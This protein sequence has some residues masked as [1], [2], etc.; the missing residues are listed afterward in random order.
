MSFNANTPTTLAAENHDKGRIEAAIAY[1]RQGWSA[2]AFSLLSGQ[3][4]EKEP[5]AQFA[6]GLCHLHAGDLASAISCFEQAL[7]L[8]GAMSVPAQETQGNNEIYLQLAKQQITEKIYLTP[9]DASFCVRFPSTARQM[10]LLALI[11]VYQKQGMNE[12]ARRLAAS[13]T[14]PVCEEYKRKLMENNL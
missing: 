13:L 2:Q 7:H 11:Y 8:L 14:G 1:F 5:A 3:G 12:P 10:V 9:M 4:M 6:L